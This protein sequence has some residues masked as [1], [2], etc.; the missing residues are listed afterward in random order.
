M[1]ETHF[2]IATKQTS[3]HCNLFT[4]TELWSAINLWLKKEMWTT[5]NVR[6]STYESVWTENFSAVSYFAVLNIHK[7]IINS[8]E[9]KHQ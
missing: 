9:N 4:S 1:C 3:N 6:W 5:K 7:I 8:K 2:N